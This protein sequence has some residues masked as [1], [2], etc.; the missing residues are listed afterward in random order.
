MLSLFSVNFT[1]PYLWLVLALILAFLSFVMGRFLVL[2]QQ[3]QRM[4]H[5]RQQ[6]YDGEERARRFFKKEGFSILEEQITQKG[7]VLVD[8]EELSFLLK[9]DFLVSRAGRTAIVE[10]K[11]GAKASRMSDR[12]TR[13]QILEYSY[14]FDVDDFYL[15]DAEKGDL[16][17]VE[18][19]P[20]RVS[21]TY[22]APFTLFLILLVFSLG[23]S[24]GYF[25]K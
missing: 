23:V 12:A 10:V 13:R 15:F 4:K 18:F 5:S 1:S 21:R 8:G 2:N 22:W 20:K 6:G 19:E 7:S 24:L 3:R 25:L 14:F 16:K 9:A 17:L 11:A